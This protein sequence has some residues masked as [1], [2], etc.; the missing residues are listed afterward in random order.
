M[1]DEDWPGKAPPRI[2][3]AAMQSSTGVLVIGARHCDKLMQPRIAELRMLG[4]W[5][6][7]DDLNQGFID[8]FGKYY[9]RVDAWKVAEAAGQ[10]FRRCGGDTANGGTLYS[11]NLY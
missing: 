9:N 10:I 5:K 6:P 11:E 4:L 2:V 7:E 3:C 1:S 8:Q